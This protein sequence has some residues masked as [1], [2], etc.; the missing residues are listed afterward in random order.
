L[1]ANTYYKSAW[2]SFLRNYSKIRVIKKFIARALARPA[3]RSFHRTFIKNGDLVFDIGAN[4]GEKVAFYLE[5]GAS[6][7]AVEPQP[8][9]V[10]K[11]R[12]KF[13]KNSRVT[14]LP[15]AVADHAGIG[16]IRISDV[17]HQLSSMSSEWIEAV[18]MSGRFRTYEWTKTLN[19]RM[20]TL[21]RLIE[22]HG[23]PHFCKIDVEG[24]ELQVLQGL[25][26]ALPC[27]SFEFHLEFLSTT[28]GCISRLCSIGNYEFN[29]TFGNEYR[30]QSPQ[31]LMES[32]IVNQLQKLTYKSLQGDIYAK[33]K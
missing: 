27:I 19:V 4:C 8:Y 30:F 16:E 1:A 7:L 20:T 33:L 9:C 2:L 18:Q 3:Q 5:M 17:R 24:F 26:E 29:F 10:N 25:T 22:I 21:D 13:S 32:E 23:V 6:V 15:E 14:I 31:W 11:L 12:K 28:I